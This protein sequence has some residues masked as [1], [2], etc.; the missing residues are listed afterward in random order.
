MEKHKTAYLLRV[1]DELIEIICGQLPP[2]LE[3][4]YPSDWSPPALHHMLA[5]TEFVITSAFNATAIAAAPR[6][7]MIQLSGIGFEKV[8]IQ[9]ATAAGITVATT[10]EGNVVPVAEHVMAL[11]LAV[12]RR[13][14]DCHL[15]LRRGQWHMM[16]YR[17][18]C[19]EL[20]GRQVGIVGLGRIGRAVAKRMLAFEAQ[21]SYFDTNRLARDE[22]AA[23]GV[24]FQPL[25]TLLAGCDVVTLHVPLDKSTEG[26]LDRGRIGIMKPGSVLINTCRGGVVDEKALYE[27]LVSGHLSGAGL[28]VFE[29]EPPDPQNPLFQLDQVVLTPHCAS[30][31]RE[32]HAEKAAAAFANMLRFLRGEPLRNVVVAGSRR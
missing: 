3:L 31:T 2:E 30:G 9:A 14:I 6:L 10:P 26:L 11:V 27:A 25:E 13:L 16:T 18:L 5:D 4:F 15:S 22:E 17:H 1:T 23:L 28:D 12:Y 24:T 7:R 19:H 20:A 21:V 8:D 32:S 29:R